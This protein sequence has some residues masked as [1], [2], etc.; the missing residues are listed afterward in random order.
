MFLKIKNIRRNIKK[1]IP[2]SIRD[3]FFSI[4]H[5]PKRFKNHKF[6]CK[7]LNNSKTL[8]VGGPSTLFFTKIPIYQKIKSLAVANFSNDTVWEGKISEGFSCN[9]YGN[10]YAYQYISDATTLLNIKNNT[11]DAILSSHCLEHVA[12]PIK[13]LFRWSEVLVSDGKMLLILPHK[14]GNFDHKRC[15]TTIEHLISDYEKDIGED[16]MTHYDEIIKLHDL[17]MHPGIKI[18]LDDHIRICK[19]NFKNRNMHHHIFSQK[20]IFQILEFC[21]FEV[22]N[23]SETNE[24][25]ITLCQKKILTKNINNT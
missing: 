15:D 1:K 10:N 2:K 22:I 11:Y 19:D 4:K 16:D 8:E 18:N 25:L 24:D 9:Y 21:N 7:H 20:L 6:I 13:A 5:I 12:N 17:D 3:Y 23:Y 14:I